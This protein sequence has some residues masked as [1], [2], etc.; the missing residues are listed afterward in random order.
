MLFINNSALNKKKKKKK[1]K[2]K[3]KNLTVFILFS[4]LKGTSPPEACLIQDSH[5]PTGK[6]NNLIVKIKDFVLKCSVFTFCRV[7]LGYRKHS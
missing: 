2:I 3:S 5:S 7:G 1:K 4:V 6:N